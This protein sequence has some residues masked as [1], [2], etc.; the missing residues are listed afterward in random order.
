M[1]E[2]VAQAIVGQLQDAGINVSLD[3]QEAGVFVGDA[4]G[5]FTG[6]TGYFFVS[7]FNVNQHLETKVTG[8]ICFPEG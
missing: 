8:E 4:T 2:E 7:G 6:V 3:I 5:D 1:G